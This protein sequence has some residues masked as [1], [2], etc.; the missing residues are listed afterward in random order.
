M[1]VEALADWVSRLRY[2]DL[3]AEVVSHAIRIITD[4]VGVALGGTAEPEVRGAALAAP[5]LGGTG[6]ATVLATGVGTSA[7]TA[8]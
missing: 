5:A 1:S 7:Y 2:E 3:P 4:T 6:R 8:A